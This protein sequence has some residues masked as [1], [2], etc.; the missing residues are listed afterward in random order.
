MKITV[1]NYTQEQLNTINELATLTG[2]LNVTASIL[3]SRGIDTAQKINDFLSPGEDKLLSPYLLND[4]GVAV[5]RISI[6][7]QNGETVVIFG[8]YDADGICATTLLYNA[9]KVYGID[10]I[11]VI[12]ERDN[13]YGLSEGVLN[14]VIENV[15]PDL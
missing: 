12:P 4:M 1:K 7:R 9:L 10:A 6:A 5:E 3:Y 13:G 11:T 14:E 15:L 8:D 2:V